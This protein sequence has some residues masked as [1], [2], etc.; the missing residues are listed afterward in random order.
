MKKLPNRELLKPGEVARFWQ[1]SRKSIYFWISQGEM[2]A[3]KKG[4]TVR[5]P[6]EEALKGRKGNEE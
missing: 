3:V 6:R 5:I 2:K 4:G 1:V